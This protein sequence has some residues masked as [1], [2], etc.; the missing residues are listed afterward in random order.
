MTVSS[1]NGSKSPDHEISEQHYEPWLFQKMLDELGRSELGVGFIYSVLDLLAARYELTDA[2]VVLV[3][4]SFGT[5][6]FR[7]GH[8]TVTPEMAARIGTS[9]GVYCE[10]AAVPEVECD[11]GRTACQ[12]SLSLHFARFSAG[13]DPLT[14]IANRRTF[15]TA[16]QTAA[17]RSAR[18][19]WA[20]TLVLCDLDDFK[21][22]NDSAGHAFGDQLLRQFGF[23]LRL[24]VRGGDT[25]ARIGG[26]EFAVILNNAEGNESSGFTD[27]LRS[28]LA[29]SGNLIDFTIGTATSPRDSTDPLELF[30]VADGRLYEKKGII[31]R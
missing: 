30:R 11:A 20:F 21:A 6:T 25:A 4:E 23:A 16:L 15:D 8:Q 26:D 27:R 7:L 24:S 2:V 3:H 17:V 28:H 9:P 29:L 31:H 19:G 12:L 5:Q 13:H 14:N 1:L 18:Y 10:P 22:V